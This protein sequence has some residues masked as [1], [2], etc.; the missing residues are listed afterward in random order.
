MRGFFI[1]LAIILTIVGGLPCRRTMQHTAKMKDTDVT[2]IRMSFRDKS[3]PFDTMTRKSLFLCGS[4]N[5]R[6]I[7][8]TQK[9]FENG[10]AIIFSVYRPKDFEFRPIQM[11]D[12]KIIQPLA[13]IGPSGVQEIVLYTMERQPDHSWK[14]GGCIMVNGLGEET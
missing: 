14:I 13:V 9:V 3:K 7:Q 4:R 10:E 11:I 2:Q 5:Q 8:N 6:K 12:D 1:A